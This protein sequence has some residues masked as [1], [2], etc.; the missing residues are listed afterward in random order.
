MD[1]AASTF[2]AE[3]DE[4]QQRLEQ[5]H[6][7]RDQEEPILRGRVT[8]LEMELEEKECKLGDCKKVEEALHDQVIQHKKTILEMD[9]V[10]SPS[11]GK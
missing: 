11:V 10:A 9:R 8:E 5:R 1:T 6:C 4:L 2:R 7:R 3:V